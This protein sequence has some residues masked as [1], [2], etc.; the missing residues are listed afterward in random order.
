MIIEKTENNI[1]IKKKID[2]TNMKTGLS[3]ENPVGNTFDLDIDKKYIMHEWLAPVRKN[4]LG[5]LE[6]IINR[7]DAL[8]EM[9]KRDKQKQIV[10]CE[11]NNIIAFSGDRG[12]GKTTA[13]TSFAEYIMNGELSAQDSETAP[14]LKKNMF[15][16]VPVIDPCKLADG[17]SLTGILTANIYKKTKDMLR[18]DGNIPFEDNCRDKLKKCSELIQHIRL[19]SLSMKESLGEVQDEADFI[20]L[21]S[22]TNFLREDIYTLINGYLE[23]CNDKIEK[24]DQ[25]RFLLVRIDDL[26]TNITHGFSV[27]D[28]L[29]SFLTI[30]NI[31][32]VSAMKTEQLTDLVE[33]KFQEDFG[34]FLSTEKNLGVHPYEMAMKY[35]EKVIPL[36]RRITIQRLDVDTIQ[37][38]GIKT[39]ETAKNNEENYKHLVTHFLTLVYQKTHIVLIKNADGIHDLI[40]DTLRS[41]C[42]A[43][44]LLES[45][46]KISDETNCENINSEALE[47]N[48]QRMET[49]L[50]DNISS[51]SVPRE[52][53]VI[54]RRASEHSV[55]GLNSFIAN[56]LYRYAKSE[57]AGKDIPVFGDD[58]YIDKIF[59]A[60]KPVETVSLGD[61]LYLLNTL[62]K[63]NPGTGYRH[64]VAAV[65]MFY[66]I[67]ITR[68]LYVYSPSKKELDEKKKV[69]ENLKA[70]EKKADDDDDKEKKKVL[71][72]E[73]E[74]AEAEEETTKKWKLDGYELV[75][76]MLGTLPCLPQ[77]RLT[78]MGFE[79][80][81]II[82]GSQV[83]LVPKAADGSQAEK[84]RIDGYDK[85][86]SDDSNTDASIF[87]MNADDLQW[88]SFFITGFN[89]LLG[90]DPHVLGRKPF[91]NR[92]PYNEGGDNM[93][94][95]SVHWFGFATS[96]LT[97]A[98]TAKNFLWLIS[99]E[100]ERNIKSESYVEAL[101]E[102]LYKEILPL[103]LHNV[104]LIDTLV[105]QMH[106]DRLNFSKKRCSNTP[107][108]G[109]KEKKDYQRYRAFYQFYDNM[110]TSYEH[111]LKSTVLHD[112]EKK[113]LLKNLKE[114]PLFEFIDKNDS[115][116]FEWLEGSSIN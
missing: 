18:S 56:E 36:P 4:A 30:P 59:K 47:Q 9:F 54:L 3:N 96:V 79:W 14:S 70:S 15:C 37:S 55:I 92:L 94:L 31:I 58:P 114:C 71:S 19:K 68:I 22:R 81:P 106:T 98:K 66:S 113:K 25:C 34:R 80:I 109:D 57:T 110:V 16:T 102:N 82:D 86:Q 43:I 23:L 2:F 112:D 46:S 17:E 53:A 64:F 89:R 75:K 24:P 108:Y 116:K 38:L 32:I 78:Q 73:M 44:F 91:N 11:F 74:K 69:V 93:T 65:K 48:L 90:G 26:D 50:I 60:E 39:K 51:N 42:H 45:F 87:D 72:E 104:D 62:A 101:N 107:E 115:K 61:I 84:L 76:K 8:R 35:L 12:S 13:M 21:L 33:Q 49:W 1:T 7:A 100:I 10:D 111:V 28:E 83:C 20:Y 88:N 5:C 97:P 29:R 40:P 6:D 105:N 52:L 27:L 77:V 63:N 41:L 103:P 95:M 99:K 67:K 85:K